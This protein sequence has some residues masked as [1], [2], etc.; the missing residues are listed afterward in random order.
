MLFRSLTSTL[1]PLTHPY[2]AQWLMLLRLPGAA[3]QTLLP[4]TTS[5]SAWASPSPAVIL[6]SLNTLF[7]TLPLSF[8]TLHHRV[9]PILLFSSFSTCPGSHILGQPDKHRFFFQ[10]LLSGPCC[11][12]HSFFQLRNSIDLTGMTSMAGT[13]THHTI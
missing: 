3:G 12:T 5:S 6:P 9:L 10:L 1:L 4:P 2:P 7:F 8:P 11:A 13:N